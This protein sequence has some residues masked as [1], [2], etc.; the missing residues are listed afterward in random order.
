MPEIKI[1]RV[2][3]DKGIMCVC[4]C[5]CTHMNVCIYVCIHIEDIYI[6]KIHIKIYVYIKD[7]V[8]IY[9]QYLLYGIFNK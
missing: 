8:C 5:V 3:G 7:V 9:T 6:H 4:V 1:E 2:K